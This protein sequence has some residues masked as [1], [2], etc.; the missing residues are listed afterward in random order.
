MGLGRVMG[1][2]I[3]QIEGLT[4]VGGPPDVIDMILVGH[5][6]RGCG[7]VVCQRLDLPEALHVR[8][9]PLSTAYM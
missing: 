8:A 1:D 3:A 2:G 9:S 6:E 5:T 7:N 4:A